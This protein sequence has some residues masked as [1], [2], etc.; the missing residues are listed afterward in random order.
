LWQINVRVPDA[1][2]VAKQVPVFVIGDS[3]AVSNGVSFWVED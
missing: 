2:S 3:G 1:P